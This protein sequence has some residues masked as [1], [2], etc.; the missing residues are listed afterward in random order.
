MKGSVKIP[1]Q[2]G[3]GQRHRDIAVLGIAL[4]EELVE[5]RGGG[6]R[7]GRKKTSPWQLGL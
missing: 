7:T 6:P 2:L 3:E 4:D 5:M 1:H